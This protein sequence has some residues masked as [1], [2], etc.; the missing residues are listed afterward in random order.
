MAKHQFAALVATAALIV[1]GCGSAAAPAA[2]AP[3]GSAA[4]PSTKPAGSGATSPAASATKLK[5]GAAAINSNLLPI[6]LGIDQGFYAKYGVT[7]EYNATGV[8][9]T[10][11]AAMQSG[12]IG[13]AFINPSNVAEAVAA[14]SD[15][16]SVMSI[17]TRPSYL[18]VVTPDITKVEDLKGKT[19]AVANPGGQA[20]VVAEVFLAQY[21]LK[22]GSTISL[23]NLGTEPTRV[24]AVQS[25]QVQG[26]IINPTFRDKIGSLKVLL[27]LR[28]KDMGLAGASLAISGPVLKSA[29]VSEGLVKGTWEGVKL[30]TD[31]TQKDKVIGGLKK[32]LQV[33]G[34]AGESAYEEIQKDFQGALPPKLDPSGVAKSMEILAQSNPSVK[35][36][37]PDKVVDSSIVDRLIAQGFK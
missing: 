4:A 12:E 18:L 14:G 33:E 24:Q 28:D 13:A 9:N 34:S 32:Y 10:T 17:G 23:I 1:T 29:A 25:G 8:G 30:V 26:T 20:S 35:N 3:A 36:I 37:T 19:F 6:Q 22:H 31:R 21:G 7:A 5:I 27:D 16:R 11:I 15:I 2:S